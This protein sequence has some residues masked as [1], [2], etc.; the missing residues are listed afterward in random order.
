MGSSQSATQ[1]SYSLLRKGFF[2]RFFSLSSDIGGTINR[3]EPKDG[4]QSEDGPEN[5][6]IYPKT[7]NQNEILPKILIFYELLYKF[8]K[9][10]LKNGRKVVY[11]IGLVRK[12]NDLLKSW[13]GRKMNFC[14]FVHPCH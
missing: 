11:T 8:R 1:D 3:G 6:W 7:W 5:K 2:E 12:I 13:T 10:M 9:F 4:N 14:P